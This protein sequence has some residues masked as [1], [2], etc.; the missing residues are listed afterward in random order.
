MKF[1]NFNKVLCLSPHPDD[2]EYS[3][4]GTICKHNSTI[5][6]VFCLTN[7]TSTDVSTNSKR[8]AEVQQFWSLFSCNNVNLIFP[9]VDNFEHYN[10]AQWTTCL[11]RMISEYDAICT[12]TNIDSHQEHIFVNS[13]AVATSRNSCLSIIEYKSPSTLH[14]WSPNYFVDIEQ[15]LDNKIGS[16][17]NSFVSQTDSTYFNDSCMKT[18]HMDYNCLKRNLNFTE[19]FKIKTLYNIG[20]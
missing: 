3:M 19:Q 6:D 18:F 4:S 15:Y 13:L 17:Q 5:F 12:T 11:D 7:G 2:V 1:L 20:K 10:V 9:E 8:I 16:L 14:E